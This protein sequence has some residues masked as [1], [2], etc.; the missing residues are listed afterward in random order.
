MNIPIKLIKWM[1]AIA[2]R[3]NKTFNHSTTF[4]ICVYSDCRQNEWIQTKACHRYLLSVCCSTKINTI[5]GSQVFFVFLFYIGCISVEIDT[6]NWEFSTLYLYRNTCVT[7]ITRL[8]L[9]FIP[10][11]NEIL[12]FIIIYN[13][14]LNFSEKNKCYS[15]SQS[16]YW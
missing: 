16:N 2:K 5:P 4:K 9:Y 13:Q 11:E 10:F 15:Y 12:L 14:K 8:F 6:D 3:A 1:C 7:T